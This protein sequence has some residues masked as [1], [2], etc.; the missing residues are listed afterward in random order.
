MTTRTRR[1]TM[2]RRR[3]ERLMGRRL[4][5]IFNSSRKSK[6]LADDS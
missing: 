4:T 2:T 1:S 6:L 5:Q 3:T